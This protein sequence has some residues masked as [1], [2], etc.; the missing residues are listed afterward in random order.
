MTTASSQALALLTDGVEAAGTDLVKISVTGAAKKIW[1]WIRHRAR[2][3]DSPLVIAA[4][5]GE[6]I[7]LHALKAMLEALEAL[8]PEEFNTML[9]N[10]KFDSSVNVGNADRGATLIVGGDIVGGDKS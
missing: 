7:E 9:K 10:V 8:Q 3:Q 5:A 1:A 6:A 4:D 2:S